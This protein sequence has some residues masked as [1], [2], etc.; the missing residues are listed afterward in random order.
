[1]PVP[2]KFIPLDPHIPRNTPFPKAPGEYRFEA[3]NYS[4]APPPGPGQVGRLSFGCPR[5]TGHCGAVVIGNGHKPPG[6][7]TWRWDGNVEA[8]TLT[9]SINCLAHDPK[10]A[11]VKYAGCGW[12]AHLTAGVFT[13][14]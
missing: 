9:P 12:H 10:D 1:M 11:S 3:M 6:E 4:P 5:G 13:G 2:A 14:E 7:K 8:P